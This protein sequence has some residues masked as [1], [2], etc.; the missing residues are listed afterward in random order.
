MGN[1]RKKG[2]GRAS[3][4]MYLRKSE[5]GENLVDIEN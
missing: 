2:L 4:E 1:G 5:Q 3:D